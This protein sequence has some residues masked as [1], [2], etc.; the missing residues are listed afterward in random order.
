M[1]IDRLGRIF[2]NRR[3]KEQPVKVE[4]RKE[5]NKIKVG[6]KTTKKTK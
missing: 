1:I 3:K 2:E 4:R 5:D 6:E